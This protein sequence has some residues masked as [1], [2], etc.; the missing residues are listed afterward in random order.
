[1]DALAVVPHG[2][3]D[4]PLRE[5]VW[6]LTPGT[7]LLLAPGTYRG[8]I[9]LPHDIELRAAGGLG[10]VTIESMQGGTLSVE[11]AERVRLVDLLLRGPKHGMGAVL[12]IYNPA[13]VTMEGCLLTGGH[14][15]GQGGGAID[16]QQGRLKL[17]RCRLTQNTAMQGGA[18]RAAGPVLVEVRN[19]VFADNVAAGVGGGGV[20]ASVAAE[21]KLVGCTFAGNAAR[22]GS[23]VL[24]GG[25]PL[26]EGTVEVHNCLFSAGGAELSAT[27]IEPGRLVLAHCVLPA[28]P[29]DV[30]Q[31]VTIGDGV[32]ARRLE[33]HAAGQSVWAAKFVSLLTGLGDPT[34]YEPDELDLRGK[35]RDRIWI[36]AIG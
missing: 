31:G 21:V 2:P 12:R 14:G 35:A 16:I 32:L 17:D 10:S 23:A 22:I 25:S 27:A 19:S 13:D 8:P 30:H 1:M 15:L 34:C 11:G 6:Q 20:F 9:A 29:E 28:L 5:R 3:T 24:A 18:L 33:V 7:C 4:P 36:G 26:G